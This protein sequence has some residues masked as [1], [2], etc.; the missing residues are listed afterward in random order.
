MNF[1]SGRMLIP[2]HDNISSYE[3]SFV[4]QCIVNTDDDVDN[5]GVGSFFSFSIEKELVFNEKQR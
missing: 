1:P 2:Q 5:T 3:I 4:M